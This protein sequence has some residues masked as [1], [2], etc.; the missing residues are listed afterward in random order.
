MNTDQT[1][2]FSCPINCYVRFVSSCNK[3]KNTKNCIFSNIL[4]FFKKHKQFFHNEQFFYA[5]LRSTLSLAY[6]IFYNTSIIND[7]RY[8]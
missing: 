1:D 5:Y 8:L 6:N 7:I 4:K 2:L 3:F